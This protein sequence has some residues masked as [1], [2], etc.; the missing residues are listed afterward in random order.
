M[1]SFKHFLLSFFPVLL[2]HEDGLLEEFQVKFCGLDGI[3]VPR[4]GKRHN[5]GVAVCVHNADGGD[6][7]L[8]AVSDGLV[9]F[10]GRSVFRVEKD[11]QIGETN[12]LA[13]RDFRRR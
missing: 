12:L 13:E 7:D 5:V 6:A 2:P 11:D 3:V 1:R 10:V 9:L 8:G 4:H